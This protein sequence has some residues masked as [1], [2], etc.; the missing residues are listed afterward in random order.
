MNEAKHF[1]SQL[2]YKRTRE[3]FIT[4]QRAMWGRDHN[5]QLYTIR[6]N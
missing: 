3:R 5:L 4:A 2:Y 6:Q 1:T